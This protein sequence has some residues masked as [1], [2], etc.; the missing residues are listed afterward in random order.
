MRNKVLAILFAIVLLFAAC[1][2]DDVSV[3]N[4]QAQPYIKEN[5]QMGL[6]LYVKTDAKNPEA[7]QM[8]VKDPSGNLSWSFTV[9]EVDYENETYYGSSDIAMPTRSAL[10]MGTWTVDLFFKDG[11]TR[12]MDFDVSYSDEDGAIERFQSQNTEKAWF[13]T[14]SNLTVLP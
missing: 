13:D 6:S 14:D 11:S 1:S 9:N 7:I 2:K 3:S 8:M 4:L 12:S 5:G 10:P